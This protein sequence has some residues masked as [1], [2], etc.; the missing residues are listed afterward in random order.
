MRRCYSCFKECEKDSVICPFCG[1]NL[2]EE[3]KEP[4]HLVPGTVLADRYIIG[5]AV[6]AG[7][8]GIIYKAWDTKL[9]T[10]IAV[11]EF[12]ASRL[13]TRAATT[14]EVI[15]NKKSQAE[16]EYR[17][18]RFLAE[19]RNM[20][21]FGA[22]KSIP[23]VFE[24][25]EENNTAYIVMELLN[26]V[27]LNEYLRNNDGKID[28]DFA[29]M[30][31]NE[32]GK[33][34]KSMHESGI[35]H[36]D[37]APD[38]I[39]INSDKELTI[40]LLDLG[41][42]KLADATEDVIDIILKPGYSPVEQYD[43]TMSIG[44][45][46]DVYALGAS[47]YVMLTGVKPD[48]STNRKIEDTLVPPHEID[49]SIPENL[50]NTVMK[51][52]ALEK[53]MR[54]KNITEFLRAVNGEKKVTTLAK[55]KKRRKRQRLAGVMAACLTLVLIGCSVLN[56]YNAKKEAELLEPATIS[57]W[58]SASEGSAEENA[59]NTI[60]ADFNATY[61][62]VTI[63][64]RAIA[65]DQYVA[66]I[67]KAAETDSLPTLFESSDVSDEILKKASDISEVLESDQ[68][69]K[70]HFLNQ[71][72][73]YYDDTKRLPLA[74]EIPMACVITNGVTAVEY[75]K[76][77]F[78]K[79]SDFGEGIK[80]AIEE[81]HKELV[82]SNFEVE[83]TVNE[84]GFLDNESNSCAVM[85][86]STMSYNRVRETLTNYKKTFV[87]PD[88]EEI[89]CNFIYEWSIGNG[90]KDELRA[91]ERILMWMLGHSYQNTLM[92]SNC[93][94]GQIPINKESFK[95][96]ISQGNLSAIEDIYKKFSFK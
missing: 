36:R 87:F 38:N 76:E 77:Y 96:K 73:S 1:E 37:V 35:I 10:V 82:E 9:E 69:A 83:A 79:L 55:E 81:A 70:C 39:Y 6:G 67:E 58:Y 93:N 95:E 27:A 24:F 7:G 22:H 16:F 51:A 78:S 30:I 65:P 44:P 31:T 85:L 60:I 74:I 4:I 75:D 49:E 86:T 5:L 56:I 46:T 57:V 94:E 42:A 13:V 21:K 80:I 29:V 50:S 52:M 11:K 90:S 64:A 61:P 53:H 12:F 20:A 92:I 19:A 25:F 62:D 17:K 71:Y 14:K 23:N 33:A 45:W 63:E 15:I 89:V 66:E 32:I 91:G 26:G 68:A 48:E 2:V 28:I 41:A 18:A 72:E 8:F 88:K 43:N 40:K 47:L 34:L 59:M 84:S 54:F 3:A